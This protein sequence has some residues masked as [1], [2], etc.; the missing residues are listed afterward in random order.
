METS[1]MV[2]II[3]RFISFVDHV[4]T[5]VFEKIPLYVDP[6]GSSI[7]LKGI[8]SF[9]ALEVLYSSFMVGLYSTPPLDSQ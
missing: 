8:A 2:V 3:G 5:I 7:L 6:Q 9:L 4:I 1:I